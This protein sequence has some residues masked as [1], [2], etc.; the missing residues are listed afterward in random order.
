M[1]LVVKEMADKL[2][3]PPKN[4]KH[5]NYGIVFCPHPQY[6]CCHPPDLFFLIVYPGEFITAVSAA[7]QDPRAHLGS[8]R[9]EYPGHGRWGPE[10]QAG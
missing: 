8:A 5:N 4:L 3:K 6:A 10:Q 9:W 7:F 1:W 2:D